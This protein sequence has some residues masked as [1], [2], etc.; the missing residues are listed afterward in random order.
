MHN[1]GDVF[2]CLR[3][4]EFYP[5][6]VFGS[7]PQCEPQITEISD[8]ILTPFALPWFSEGGFLI[9]AITVLAIFSFTYFIAKA[10]K[11]GTAGTLI[12]VC[13]GGFAAFNP[14]LAVLAIVSSKR[15]MEDSYFRSLQ[16]S[17]LVL[18]TAFAVSAAVAP[19]QLS[20]VALSGSL[21]LF[22]ASRDWQS[23]SSLLLT[24]AIAI[25][26]VGFL[27]NNV[28]TLAASVV[29]LGFYSV[30][31]PLGEKALVGS[32]VLASLALV[33]ELAIRLNFSQVTV[34]SGLGL[35]ISQTLIV[36]LAVILLIIQ[37]KAFGGKTFV[38]AIAGDSG[39]GKDTLAR[40]ISDSNSDK[41]FLHLSG[42]DSHR[43]ERGSP[44]WAETTHLNPDAND[45][46]RMSRDISLAAKK[47]FHSRRTYDH[48]TGK[49][50]SRRY[51]DGRANS[52]VSG[53]HAAAKGH[54]SALLG[55]NR[56]PG[57]TALQLNGKDPGVGIS[58]EAR[59]EALEG[60]AEHC[61]A[62]EGRNFPRVSSSKLGGSN[63]EI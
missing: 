16:N 60:F 34:T 52:I 6:R 36:S 39:T 19:D 28:T 30:D 38:V 50:T 27:V 10:A 43:W 8:S 14:Q 44:Q 46:P 24:V 22:L 40:A 41:S 61:R 35:Q 63:G 18:F 33:P 17:L 9:G 29:F 25:G 5:G 55:P 62:K 59:S 3:V 57:G 12:R 58:L 53:L 37:G 7:F 13:V 47:K 1:S 48:R 21:A 51:F 32:G 26:V 4:T 23:N 15:K 2:D 42:D 45:L 20:I 54:Q 11:S 49:F 56:S 31:R